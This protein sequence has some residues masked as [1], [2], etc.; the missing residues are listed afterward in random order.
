MIRRTTVTTCAQ[1]CPSMRGSL[2]KQM[3]H[4]M[5]T[6]EK[7]Y[8]CVQDTQEVYYKQFHTIKKDWYESKLI[9]FMSMCVSNLQKSS[10]VNLIRKFKVG[11]EIT[12]ADQI[13][14]VS[15]K[16]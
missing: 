5:V 11:E 10:A 2:A 7:D 6:A 8:Q 1:K 13:I 4:S 12:A 3:A 16:H 9:Q 14:P 15:G